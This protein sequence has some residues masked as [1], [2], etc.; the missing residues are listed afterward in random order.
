MY[1]ELSKYLSYLLR[2]NPKALNLNMNLNGGWVNVNEL[3]DKIHNTGKYIIN[4]DVLKEIVKTDNKQRY[5]FS[6]DGQFIRAN[7]GHSIPN[8]NL[9]LNGIV[10]PEYLFH[11]TSIANYNHI[12]RDKMIKPMK[13]QYVH[14]CTKPMEALYVGSRH[15]APIVLRIHAKDMFNDG[16]EFYISENGVYLTLG[17]PT[18]Y[19]DT[20]Y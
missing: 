9:D 2:H 1:T 16:Y 20:K 15:G 19:V 18:K 13:R 12:C 7:Q 11:G 4:L 17:I 5:S 10:P 3:I 8:I 6:K 14:L